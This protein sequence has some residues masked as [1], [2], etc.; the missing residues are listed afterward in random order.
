[1]S[2]TERLL[3]HVGAMLALE[4]DKIRAEW[5]AGL[6]ETARGLRVSGSLPRNIVPNQSTYN[7]SHRLMG[8][9]VRAVAGAVTLT[10]HDG[11]D[12]SGDVIGTVV[13]SG[14][15]ANDTKPLGTGV[16]FS[17]GLFTEVTAA[18]GASVAGCVWVAP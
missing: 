12:A 13:L 7:G 5:S 1:V 17:E 11:H 4:G 15:G 9:S 14:D 2:S 8:W 6:A 3:E 16:N 10:F 18:A